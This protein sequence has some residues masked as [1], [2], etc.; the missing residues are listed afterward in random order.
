MG[1]T[2]IVFLVLPLIALSW[3]I[4]CWHK[5]VKDERRRALE[6]ALKEYAKG[7]T[8]DEDLFLGQLKTRNHN[9]N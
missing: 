2:I 7:L 3:V 4:A 5:R 6:N 1:S 8:I 9:Q